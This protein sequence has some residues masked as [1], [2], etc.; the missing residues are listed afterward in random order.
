MS[1]YAVLL[2]YGRFDRS[3]TAYRRYVEAFASFVN[4]NA[5]DTIILSGG[6]TDPKH[7]K[8]SEAGSVFDYIQPLLKRDV[9]VIL[10]ERAL[11][12]RQNIEFSK[13]FMNLKGGDSAMVFCDNVRQP[14]IM[15]F[16]LHFWFGLAKIEIEQYFV[17]Y[18][19]KYYLRHYTTEQI[20]NEVAKGLTYKNV[21]VKPYR[22]RTTIEAA[23]SQEIA[24]LL[25]VNTLYDKSLDRRLMREIKIKF[26]LIS[27]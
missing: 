25:E 15:W 1:R 16:I 2:G 17:D 14:K 5:V 20:G 4:K 3:N 24:T 22:M 11:T 6:Y 9:G 19:Q 27:P 13:K 26:G 8:I 7:P 23:V 12:T 18:G 10:E 21:I